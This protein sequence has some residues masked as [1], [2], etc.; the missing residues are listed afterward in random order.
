MDAAYVKLTMCQCLINRADWGLAIGCMNVVYSFFLLQFWAV[1]LIKSGD[2][3]PVKW[4]LLY[5]FNVMFNVITMLRVVKRESAAVFYWM[6]ETGGLLIFRVHHIYC[7]PDEFWLA[8]SEMYR[9]TNII[10]DV[11]IGLSMLAMIYV[12]CGLRFEPDRTFSEEELVNDCKLEAEA[13]KKYEK[14]KRKVGFEKPIEKEPQ[15]VEQEMEMQELNRRA[16][17]KLADLEDPDARSLSPQELPA[18]TAPEE[19]SLP[20]GIVFIHE[21]PEPSAPPKG[22]LC[23]DEDF[24]IEI[25]DIAAPGDPLSDISFDA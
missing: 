22:S 15:L 18:P 19:E 5:A 2:N 6:C 25:N 10:I 4:V 24:F 20:S 23:L 14:A 13:A 1:E 17:I 21:N 11:Y 9:V 3:Y 12:I 16:M 8:K 7:H